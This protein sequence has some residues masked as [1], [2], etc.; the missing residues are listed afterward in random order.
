MNGYEDWKKAVQNLDFAF[1]PIVNIWSGRCYGFEALLRDWQKAGFGSIHEIFDRAYEQREIYRVD[2]MLREKLVR[3]FVKFRDFQ[4]SRLFFNLDS[5]VLEMPDYTFGNTCEILSKNGVKPSNFCF[6]LSERFEDR[7]PIKT[8][9]ILKLYQQQKFK[10]AMDDFG[11]GFAGLQMLY[12]SEP[13]FIKIDRFFIT[14]IDRDS[15]KRLFIANIVNLAHIMSILV[16]AEGIETEREFFACRGIGCDFAQGYFIQKPTTDT[17]EMKPIY[18]AIEELNRKDRRK[19]A[20][21]HSVI[22]ELMEFPPAV[23][24]DTPM[25]EVLKAFKKD[26]G[27]N[28]FPVVNESGEPLGLIREEEI[29]DYVYSPYGFELFRKKN[30]GRTLGDFVFRCAATEVNATVEKVLS[31]FSMEGP[32]EGILV[33]E[34]G[35]YI[36]FLSAKSLLRAV[37]EKRVEEAQDQNPLTRLPGNPRV[38]EFI[39]G[40]LADPETRPVFVYLDIDNFK[41]FNDRF[42]FRLGD[43]AIALFAHLLRETADKHRYFIGHIGGDDFFLGIDANGKKIDR[44]TE[45]VETLCIRFEEEARLL[46]PESVRK[47]GCFETT[48]RDGNCREFPLLSISAAVLVIGSKHGLVDADDLSTAIAELKKQVK[49]SKRR[50]LINV[51]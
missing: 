13:D 8:R 51:L 5:R 25:M 45:R 18:P 34:N 33:T 19:A 14:D 31:N 49:A 9:S 41:P 42:G 4:H 28:F 46:F 40:T 36:G 32:G 27:R 50:V 7:S 23:S 39:V 22:R 30:N 26:K 17:S 44:I 1:Q 47:A 20:N 15:K 21:D 11:A 16:I 37:Y 43:R 24:I 6:E 29:K 3:K 12:N 38:S 10:I 35:G 48:D 2:L